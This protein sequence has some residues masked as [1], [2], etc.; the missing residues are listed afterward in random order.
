MSAIALRAV[1][2]R[3]GSQ[4]ALDELS[5]EVP[6]GAICGL[7]GPNGS[8]KTTTMG[9]IGGLIRPQRGE[10]DLL[11]GGPFDAH[12]HAGR[13]SLMPQDAV[14]NPNLRVMELLTYYARLLGMSPERSRAEA[15]Q[16]LAE[17]ELS[18]RGAFRYGELSHGMRRRFSIAQALIGDPELILLDEPTSGLDPELVVS[19]RRLLMSYRGRATL[20]V[21][22]HIL[23]ELETLCDH[24]V[25][26]DSGR[27]VRQ[28]P[29]DELTS[30][31]RV[32]RYTLS[33]E[34]DLSQL[35]AAIPDCSISWDAPVLTLQSPRSRPTEEINRL[36]L[37][38]LLKSGAGILQVQPGEGLEATYLRARG[39][40]ASPGS[41]QPGR[42]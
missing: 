29:L 25:F 30:A 26:I 23:S 11:E 36:C 16:R 4:R 19:V 34:P 40:A 32:V 33:T 38:A 15:S 28:G 20:L 18:D 39:A 41:G 8:G 17:V 24:L 5:F 22:S 6:H 21:S 14:P 42:R 31:D 10:V 37:S 27:C 35:S 1:V 3:Y 9:I 12:K 2:K 7:V 13:V